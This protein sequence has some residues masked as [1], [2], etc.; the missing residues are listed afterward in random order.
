ML[1]LTHTKITETEKDGNKDREALYKLM[2]CCTYEIK[3]GKT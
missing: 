2:K 1:N 3:Q